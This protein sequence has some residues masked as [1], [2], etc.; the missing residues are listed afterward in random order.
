MRR[1]S[2]CQY[3]ASMRPYMYRLYNVC[4]LFTR[5]FFFFIVLTK[6]VPTAKLRTAVC[7]RTNDSSPAV[8]HDAQNTYQKLLCFYV[9]RY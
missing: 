6:A 9:Q 7:H 5:L 4:L 3:S 8:Q 2:D 1:F